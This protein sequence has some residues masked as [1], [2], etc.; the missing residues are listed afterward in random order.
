MN[1]KTLLQIITEAS[2]EQADSF[3]TPGEAVAKDRATS[4]TTDYRSR[5]AARKRAERSKQVPRDRKSKAELLKDVIVVKTK[6]N[7]IQLIF[8]DSFDKNNHERIS[9]TDAI[10][11]EEAKKVAQDPQFEQ[12]RAS[13][14]LLGNTKEKPKSE[15]KE[16]KKEESK[17]K[18]EKKSEEKKESKEKSEEK[19]ESKEKSSEG[20][21]EK[22]RRLSKEEMLTAMTKMSAE[23]LAM[24][25][26]EVR[27]DYFKKQRVPPTNQDFDNTTFEGL[28]VQF[29]ISPVSSL[30]FNQQVL[31]A[32]LFLSKLKVGAGQQE[33]QTFSAMNPGSTDFTKRAYLQAN[34][35]LSQIGDECLNNLLS[36]AEGG[37]KQMYKE[38]S[39]DMKCGN[40]KFKIE[41]GGEFTV[42]TDQMNQSNKLFKGILATALKT[43]FVNPDVI[44]NDPGIKKMLQTVSQDMMQTSNTLISNQNLQIILQNPK[45]VEQLKK[46]PVILGNG[47]E[48]GTVLDADGNLNPAASMES[49][50]TKIEKS[51]KNIFKK[52]TNTDTSLVGNITA[53]AIL[54]SYLRG[55]GLKTPDQQ[56]NHL[57]TAN[58]VFALTDDY[59]NEIS[60][61]AVLTVKPAEK[62]LSNDN[63]A[64]LKPKAIQNLKKWRALIE[65]NEEAKMPSLKELVTNAADID[66]LEHAAEYLETNMDFDF[67][68]SL[69]PG[70]KPKDINSV[71]YNYVR[72][73]NKVTKI[74]VVRG[75]KVANQLVSEIYL[76]LNDVLVEALTNDFVLS[77]LVKINLITN[78]EANDLLEDSLLLEDQTN[79]LK[80]LL[81]LMLERSLEVPLKLHFVEQFLNEKY[82]RD[83]KMEYRNY[84]GKP[85]QKKE[86]AARTR[87]RELMIKKGKAKRGDGKDIDHKKP[88]RS[89]GS[90]GEGNLRKRDKSSNRADNGHHKG[91][92]QNKDWK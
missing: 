9:K 47:T 68:A 48:A 44:Q 37:T 39:V 82:K 28:S 21:E 65:Q 26:P 30:P 27:E 5:D 31:N 52:E 14:L 38:G 57:V 35:I 75:D 73:G 59:I 81:D 62:P 4:N 77:N 49:Y 85:K 74:P 33:M 80:N 76:A 70:F 18:P 7:R 25:P 17:E 63:L 11:Y 86:R 84:H 10:T 71:E 12:T 42:S 72:I 45:Y 55:D 54:R 50:L 2:R 19:K 92:K 51:S 83:Y 6:S 32:I 66:P 36:A 90:N 79:N 67:N 8:K 61:N 46:T 15:K 60:K 22:P 20:E 13:K 64:N 40:Y 23:Q 89:G 91:E 29:G 24:L 16:G 58:G 1:F 34:K 56:P 53:N 3:R 69:I 78:T 41:A 88:L 43:S 87:A